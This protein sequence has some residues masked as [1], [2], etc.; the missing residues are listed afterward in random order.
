MEINAYKT[1]MIQIDR[2][3]QVNKMTKTDVVQIERNKQTN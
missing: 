2:K 3:K 1:D